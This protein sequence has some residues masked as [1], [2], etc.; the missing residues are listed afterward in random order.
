MSTT[1][2]TM[3]TVSTTVNAPL[4]K[5][6]RFWT[7]PEH[8][9]KWNSA[10][11]DWWTPRAENDLRTGGK[12]NSRMEARDGSFGFDFNGTYT[13]VEP[14][15]TI[16]YE[17]EDGRV[18]SISFETVGNETLV[19]EVFE[20]ESTNSIEMQQFGWQAIVDNFKKY[21][22][23]SSVLEKIHFEIG[24]DA[25]VSK[26]YNTMLDPVHYTAWTAAFNP[27]SYFE[28]SWETGADI[29]FIGADEN[30]NLGGMVS[31]IKENTPNKK[32]VIEH[33]GILV[34]NKPVTS[35]PEVEG[36]AGSTEEYTF[37]D[38]GDATKLEVSMDS[39][40]DYKAYFE[41]TWPEALKLLKSIC[42]A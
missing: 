15:K 23:N 3:I 37:I 21:V 18:V 32:V 5:V 27:G 39:N 8:I 6:W 17:M 36:W 42:E 4:E 25:P 33:L 40:Q 19:T 7:S 20:A 1:E 12:F 28:G 38:L 26:V 22:E 29:H 24:I 35:G 30:G 2:K 11:D 34:D 14:Q 10:S 16:E 13:L 41:Q 9:M 31:R